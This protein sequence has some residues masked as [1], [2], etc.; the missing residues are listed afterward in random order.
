MLEVRELT[1]ALKDR[2]GV[3]DSA[4]APMAM[5]APAAAPAPAEEKVEKTEFDVK[6][7]GFDSGKKIAI[8]KEVRAITGLGL[9]E[10]KAAVEGAPKV[11]KAGV[12][13]NEAEELQR[14]LKD[15]GAEVELE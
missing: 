2:L 15:L 14:K 5:A 3:D 10:A 13:K 9:K 4:L 12:S 1:D 11:I 8:I 7:T 6:L